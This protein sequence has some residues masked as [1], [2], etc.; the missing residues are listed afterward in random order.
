MIRH[1]K[2]PLV[3]PEMVLPTVPELEVKGAFNA[4]ATVFEDQVIL[5][6]RIAERCKLEPGYIGVPVY[7]FENGASK[8]EI[9]RFKEND[10]NIRLKDTRG[11]VYKGVDYL[12]TLSTIRVAWSSDGINFEVDDQPFLYP[13]VPSEQYGCEDARI[14]KIENAY[15]IN[16][17]AISQDGWATALCTTRDFKTVSRKGIIFYP[18]DK[19]VCLFPEKIQGRYWALHRPHNEGFGKP[20]IWISSSSNLVDWGEH[21]CLIR[22]RDNKWERIKIGGGAAPIKTE[23]GWLE[24]YHGKGDDSIYYL[25]TLLLDLEDPAQVIARGKKP[26]LSPEKEYETKGFFPN[27]VF[28]NGVIERNNGEIYLYYGACDETTNLVVTSVDELLNDVVET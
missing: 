8:L 5:L 10:S 3:T 28:S 16:Y 24:V 4:G 20:S 15:Y 13:S 21:R 11:V 23:E 1:E 26:F 27:V 6:L 22:P 12:S 17:T 7:R 2:N 19:D 14:Q 9:L 18:P 25:F